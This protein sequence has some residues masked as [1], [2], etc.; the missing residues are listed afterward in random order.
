MAGNRLIHEDDDALPAAAEGAV[1]G[2]AKAASEP[3]A[4]R[5]RAGPYPGKRQV[6]AHI[7]REL[8][9]WL[10]AISAQTDKPMIVLMEE[11]LSEYVQRHAAQKKFGG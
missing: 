2:I 9:L 1:Q 11:A 7:P 3:R 5:R 6:T 4:D 8:F 10:K